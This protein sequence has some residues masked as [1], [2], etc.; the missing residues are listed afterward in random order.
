MLLWSK[1]DRPCRTVSFCMSERTPHG[2]YFLY[3]R[4]GSSFGVGLEYASYHNKLCVALVSKWIN[5][6]LCGDVYLADVAL[7][8][9][10]VLLE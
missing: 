4:V 6:M 10:D 3:Y 7:I 9:C 2:M 1:R 5:H 8:S